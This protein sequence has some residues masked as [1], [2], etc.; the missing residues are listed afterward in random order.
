MSGD[1]KNTI[2][3]AYLGFNYGDSVGYGRRDNVNHNNRLFEVKTDTPQFEIPVLLL[4]K[5]PDLAINDLSSIVVSLYTDGQ[6]TRYKTI[7]RYMLDVLIE[8]YSARHLVQLNA[9]KGSDTV[10]YYGTLGSVFRENF[11]PVMM[12]SWLV[13]KVEAENRIKY[14]KPVLHLDPQIFLSQSDSMEKYLSRK[15]VNTALT[16]KV[17]PP[18]GIANQHSIAVEIGNFP[19]SLV[20]TDLPSISTTRQELLQV[21]ID[22]LDEFE[23]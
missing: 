16:T 21:A 15:L 23:Q 18:G 8:R 20:N 6:E 17:H 5:L 13:E 14:I 2:E 10:T 12:M 22:H 19:F 4:P 1:L 3:S 7:D 11:T 9:K